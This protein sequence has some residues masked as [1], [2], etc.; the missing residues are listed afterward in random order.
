MQYLGDI[1]T[2]HLSAFFLAALSR[3]PSPTAADRGGGPELSIC[4][5]ASTWLPLSRGFFL[6][7]E[8]RHFQTSDL[9]PRQKREL[10]NS[11]F[12]FSG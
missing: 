12:Q 7:C 10:E 4:S 11:V 8:G 1:C 3:T 6:H 9:M 2:K 5:C